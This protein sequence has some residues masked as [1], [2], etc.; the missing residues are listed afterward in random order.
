MV[1]FKDLVVA[2]V[3]LHVRAVYLAAGVLALTQ[4]ADVEVIVDDALHGDD[5]PLVLHL[6]RRR[7]TLGLAPGALRHARRGYALVGEVVCDAL[8]APAADVEREYLPHYLRLGGDDLKL[9][10]LI[11]DVA[12]GRG[13]D[14]ASVLL[15]ALH[16]R[17]HLAARICDGHFVHKEL[18]LYFHPVVVIREVYT[19]ADGDD[20]QPRVAQ[21]LQLHKAAAVAARETGEVLDDEDIIL[22]RH[23]LSAQLLIALALL[24]GVA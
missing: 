22:V 20:A 23:E 9:L 5:R 19:V 3:L 21:I 12:V 18:E 8:I 7:F 15:T 4:S 10:L 11:N 24:K 6:A 17:A 1:V 14:P 13:A 16:D 2:R